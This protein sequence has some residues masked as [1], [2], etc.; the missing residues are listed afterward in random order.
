[1]EN[2]VENSKRFLRRCPIASVAR[3]CGLEM[4]ELLLKGNVKLRHVPRK[5]GLA[6]LRLT[7][8][9]R[10]DRRNAD[11]PSD[12]AHQIENASGVVHLFLAERPH[13]STIGAKSRMENGIAMESTSLPYLG[14]H[15]F[16]MHRAHGVH[17]RLVIRIRD[18]HICLRSLLFIGNQRRTVHVF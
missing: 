2:A 9:Q 7:R 8:D 6:R 12:I 4:S 18:E 3:E 15:F 17:L 16:I 1:L 11:A 10:G 14:F 5:V 13:P